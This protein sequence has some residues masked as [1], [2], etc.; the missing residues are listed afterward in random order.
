MLTVILGSLLPGN[1]TPIQALDRLHLN[2][3]SGARYGLCCAGTP[4]GAS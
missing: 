3:K 1:P 4:S 2:D